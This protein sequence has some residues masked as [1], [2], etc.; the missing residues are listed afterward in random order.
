MKANNNEVERLND[1]KCN[2]SDLE[3]V[4]ENLNVL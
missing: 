2:K 4:A 3:A 1:I